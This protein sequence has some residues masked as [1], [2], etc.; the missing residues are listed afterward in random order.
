MIEQNNLDFSTAPKFFF[1]FENEYVDKLIEINYGDHNIWQI[2]KLN[3]Y[4][5]ILNSNGDDY[6]LSSKKNK[7]QKLKTKLK[8]LFTGTYNLIKLIITNYNSAPKI[9]FVTNSVDRLSLKENKYFSS[10]FDPI[11][12]L[13]QKIKTK[14]WEYLSNEKFPSFS[15][16]HNNIIFAETTGFK[17]IRNKKTAVDEAEL[18]INIWNQFCKKQNVKT[19]IT[20]EIIILNCYKFYK[21]FKFW[22]FLF[23]MVKPKNIYSSEKVGTGFMAAANYLKISIYEFQHGNM[24]KY[25]PHYVWNS[26]FNNLKNNIKPDFLVL[27]GNVGKAIATSTNYYEA[28]EIFTIGYSKIDEYRNKK[29]CNNGFVFFALQPMMHKL[30]IEIIKVIKHLSESF[31]I[32]VKFHPLQS[33]N[34]IQEYRRALQNSRV[35]IFNKDKSVYDCILESEIIISHVSTVLEEALSLG[36]ISITI[37]TESLP[38][39]IHNMTGIDYLGEVIIPKRMDQIEEYLIAYF[40]NITFKRSELMKVKQFVYNLYEKNYETNAIKILR[41]A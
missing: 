12:I 37:S 13:A 23:K 31:K 10:L 30:N 15:V 26:K 7:L 33:D 20:K 36:K 24:D 5:T 6:G 28:K 29:A 1:D 2:V 27:F 40:S 9:L 4:Y 41:N 25:Y 35:T 34:E 17:F 3:L 22:K 18:F 32:A 21:H 19:N 8:S 14:H 39:G 38:Q 11:L 16:P